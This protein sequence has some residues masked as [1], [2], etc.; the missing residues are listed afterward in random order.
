MKKYVLITF[1]LRSEFKQNKMIEI[2]HERRPEIRPEIRCA[3]RHEIRCLIW[4]KTFELR[5]QYISILVLH[6]QNKEKSYTTGFQTSDFKSEGW[7]H[8]NFSPTIK[9]KKNLYI[10]LLQNCK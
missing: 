5:Y 2:R 3:T 10:I 7:I 6:L 9:I 1:L 4:N 8:M